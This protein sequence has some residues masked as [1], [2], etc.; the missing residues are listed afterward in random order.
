MDGTHHYTLDWRVVS[1]FLVGHEQLFEFY[2]SQE[3][4]VKLI[5]NILVKYIM[6]LLNKLVIL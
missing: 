3:M 6:M 4:Y 1:Q 5:L 2:R